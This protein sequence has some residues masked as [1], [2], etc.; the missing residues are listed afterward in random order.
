MI[1]LKTAII[2]YI[3]FDIIW[4][5]VEKAVFNIKHGKGYAGPN[6]ISKR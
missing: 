5:C 4:P 6:W 2:A 3:R 1:E